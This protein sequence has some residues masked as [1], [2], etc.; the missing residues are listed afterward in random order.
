MLIVNDREI[1]G[2]HTN[3]KGMNGAGLDDYH[4]SYRAFCDYGGDFTAVKIKMIQI[5]NCE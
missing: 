3:K 5:D 2:K 4:T 1:M